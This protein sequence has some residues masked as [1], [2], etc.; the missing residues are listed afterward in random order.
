MTAFCATAVLAIL[1]LAITRS[2][3]LV[4][5]TFALGIGLAMCFIIRS[6][7]KPAEQ[8]WLEIFKIFLPV[9][10]LWAFF[11]IVPP[12]MLSFANWLA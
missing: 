4:C 7:P 2:G 1:V 6:T 11:K 9:A 3:L 8:R 5:I 12:L 10:G